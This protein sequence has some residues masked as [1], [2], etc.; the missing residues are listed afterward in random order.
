M[1]AMNVSSEYVLLF[2]VEQSRDEYIHINQKF[3]DCNKHKFLKFSKMY[4]IYEVYHF[5]A[6]V[7]YHSCCIISSVMSIHITSYSLYSVI[8]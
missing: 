5:K 1:F 4:Y 3:A 2:V 8:L 7:Y 6:H